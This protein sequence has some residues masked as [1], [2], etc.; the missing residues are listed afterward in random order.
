MKQEW[1]GTDMLEDNEL[2]NTIFNWAICDCLDYWPLR[3][4]PT[5]G[6]QPEVFSLYIVTSNTL[7]SN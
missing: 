7:L 5:E 3:L 4:F 1:I 6:N 2:E